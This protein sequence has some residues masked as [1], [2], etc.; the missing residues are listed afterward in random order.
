MKINTL[1]DMRNYLELVRSIGYDITFESYPDVSDPPFFYD[2]HIHK[3]WELKFRSPEHPED[4]YLISVIAP[5]TVHCMT[6]REVAMD[7]TH[8][9]INITAGEANSIWKFHFSE[10]TGRDNL[11]PELLQTATRYTSSSRY[12]LLRQDLIGVTL[13]NLQL[14]IELSDS[15]AEVAE[16]GRTTVEIALD[17]MENYYYKVDLSIIDIARFVGVSPQYLNMAF[18]KATGKTTRQNL[19]AVRL[20]HAREL[21]EDSIYFIKDVAILTGWRSPFYFSNCYHRCYGIPP[22]CHAAL[23]PSIQNTEG[24][25]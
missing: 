15:E 1:K 13:A 22:R 24:K 3:S 17:Y 21:L 23:S 4:K 6:R 12:D 14:I 5:G 8:H 16:R 2:Y 18:R 11:I 25:M 20:N 19:I 9:S 7:I 10:D